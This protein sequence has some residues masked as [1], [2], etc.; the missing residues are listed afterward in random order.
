M[1]GPVFFRSHR[2]PTNHNRKDQLSAGSRLIAME[3]QAG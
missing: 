3:G 2:R 1:V